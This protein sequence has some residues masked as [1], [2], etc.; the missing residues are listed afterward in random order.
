MQKILARTP[1]AMRWAPAPT[2]ADSE[3]VKGPTP[4]ATSPSRGAMGMVTA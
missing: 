3:R 2:P 1:N 4:T